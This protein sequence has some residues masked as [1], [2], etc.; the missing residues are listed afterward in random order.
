MSAVTDRIHMAEAL[1]LA[2]QR[3]LHHVAESARGLCTG[4]RRQNYRARLASNAPVKRTR[5]SMRCNDAKK[6]YGNARGATAY[7]T[8][9]PC[10]HHGK[11]PPCCEALV[12]EGITRV[13][14]ATLDPN[15]L[16]AGR[17]LEYLRN[18]GIA[19]ESGLLEHEARQFNIGFMSRMERGIGRGCG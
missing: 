3:P 19:V 17:G 15:P 10:S 14:A 13:V 1:H 11:T 2:R 16:V 6:Y 5:K 9:E 4:A 18:A 7:V 12:A 8:L